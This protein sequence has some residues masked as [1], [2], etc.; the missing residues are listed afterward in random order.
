LLTTRLP[1][2]NYLISDPR[3]AA[4]KSALRD[5][6]FSDKFSERFVMFD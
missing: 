4:V 6:H 5:W 1:F 3:A 2:E